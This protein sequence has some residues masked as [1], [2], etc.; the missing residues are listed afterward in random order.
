M[1]P[2]LGHN[3]ENYIQHIFTI[4]QDQ[5]DLNENFDFIGTRK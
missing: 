3:R 5:C 2:S 4:Y 1:P